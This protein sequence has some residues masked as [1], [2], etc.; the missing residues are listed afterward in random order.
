MK[1]WNLNKGDMFCLKAD[2]KAH[3]GTPLSTCAWAA[4]APT[5]PARTVALATVM[6]G[7]DR[8]IYR[9]LDADREVFPVDVAGVT[10]GRYTDL[11][12]PKGNHNGHS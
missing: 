2:G 1:A 7:D 6:E 12:N 10:P 3:R 11:I 8:R 4:K 5:Q 9:S